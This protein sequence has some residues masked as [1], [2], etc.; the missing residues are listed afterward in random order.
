MGFIHFR[1]NGVPFFTQKNCY[2][3]KCRSLKQKA[4]LKIPSVL[5][6]RTEGLSIRLGIKPL[7][8]SVS[9]VKTKTSLHFAVKLV[10]RN[11]HFSVDSM[12]HLV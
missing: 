12:I 5:F 7:L 1:V 11:S 10:E 3:K 2:T 9:C 4:N 6:R 8:R